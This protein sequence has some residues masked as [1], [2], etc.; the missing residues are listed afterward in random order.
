MRMLNIGL[1]LLTSAVILVGCSQQSAD[2]TPP[3]T[4]RAPTPIYGQSAGEVRT[5]ISVRLILSHAPRLDESAYVTLVITSTLDAPGA[6]AEIV[7]P[8]G[9]VAADGALTWA[10]D[11]RA[12]QPQ[13]LQATIKFVQEGNW[14]LEGKAVAAAG[15]RDVWGDMAV[16]YLHI[17]REAGQVGFPPEPNAPHSAGQSTAPAATPITP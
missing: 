15:G 1:I 16:I 7:L 8:P 5:P 4:P 12:Q 10:G 6:A 11:L 13:R 9:A 14:T 3:F 2:Q 17:T